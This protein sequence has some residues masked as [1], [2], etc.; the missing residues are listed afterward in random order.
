MCLPNGKTYSFLALGTR[1]CVFKSDQVSFEYED[2]GPYRDVDR[3][4]VRTT[5]SKGRMV[6]RSDRGLKQTLRTTQTRLPVSRREAR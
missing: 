5:N 4:T 3:Q 6:F 2:T 1:R